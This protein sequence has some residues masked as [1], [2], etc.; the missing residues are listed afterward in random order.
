MK[1]NL[2]YYFIALVCVCLFIWLMF[3]VVDTGPKYKCVDGVMYE[4]YMTGDVWVKTQKLCVE[5]K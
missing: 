4:N 3:T 1:Q 2:I 5:I